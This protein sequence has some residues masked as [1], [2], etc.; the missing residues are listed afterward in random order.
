MSV[1][2]LPAAALQFAVDGAPAAAIV[3][4]EDATPA[5]QTAAND[6][7]S[8]LG[9]VCGVEF[10]VVSEADAPDGPAVYVGPTDFAKAQ[11]VDFDALGAEEWIVRTVDDAL[12]LVGGR[13]RGTLYAVS[14][15][16]EDV[17]GVHWWNPREDFA[18]TAPAL[19][20]GDID[21]RGEPVLRYRDIYMLYGYDGG[22]FAARSRL[23]RQ[24]DAR[25]GPE[26]GGSMNYGPP[27]HVHTFNKYVPPAEYFADHPEWFSLINGERLGERSQLC[28]TNPELR[29][30]MVAKLRDY[31]ETSW[32]AA[33]EEGL[34][35]PLVF[36]VSQNDWRNYCQCDNCK[37][38]AEAEES[39][40]GPVIDFVNYIADAIKDDYP[41]IFIGTL[42]YQ[43][44]EHLPKTIHPRDNVVVRLCDT[45]SGQT[46][47]LTHESNNYFSD[48][49][50]EWSTGAK[51]LRV[52]D[53][54][55]TY[56]HPR[57]MPMPSAQ[58]YQADYQFYVDN[59]VRGVFTELE[60]PVL[61]DMRDFK[62]WMMCK[63]LEDP[64][65]DYESL[66]DTF[67][68]GFYGPAGGFV[69]QYLRALEAASELKPAHLAMGGSLSAYS[70]LD[71]D[72][73]IRAQ[74]IFDQAEAAVADDETLL[75]RVRHARLPIDRATVYSCRR[76]TSEWTAA[77]N[78]IEDM[79]LDRDA[80]AAR[81]RETWTFEI[82]VRQP[83]SRQDKALAEMEA[84]LAEYLSLPVFVAL[85]ERFQN[86]PPGSVVDFTADM[87]RNWKKMVKVVKDDEADAG[88]TGR[89]EFPLTINADNHPLEKYLLP[90]QWGVYDNS[91][92]RAVISTTI[93]PDD[94]AGPG[95]HWYKLGSCA[96]GSGHYVYFFWS[97][98]IQVDVCSAYSADAPDQQFDVWA[99]I[100]FEGPAFPHG[101]EDDAN[102]ICV[103]RTIL[104][105]S[106]AAQ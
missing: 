76:L 53:Y 8:Y 102:A 12:I 47:P 34:P 83:E 54:A 2:T 59:N 29:E 105:K 40:A 32:A 49:L 23:N 67:M 62:I 90:M 71:V 61:A 99:H 95:Y 6:V 22:R 11:G 33:R 26:Y 28:L 77:G 64:Y 50:A 42:A 101:L 73:C 17:V 58:N 81:A 9:R 1:T 106:D 36:E 7:A 31:I 41:E 82:G 48:R 86:L 21:L 69:K 98:I 57:G 45:R 72:F 46:Q 44:T 63:L 35:V 38:L 14:H 104:V 25:V 4:A 79:P 92:I 94:V 70:Y 10:E 43:Y 20:V 5:E 74:A 89:L 51:N 37:A 80:I 16:L 88:A 30:F 68:D 91:N 96:I 65:R 3:L 24:G 56:A 78:A 97:W 19:Q 103:E 100:K 13:P 52:W 75:R 84:E 39:E 27:Y 87:A 60:T 18:P 85:P 15:F 93:K 66:V 55:I